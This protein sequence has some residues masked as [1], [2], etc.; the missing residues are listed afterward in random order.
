MKK[1]R[2]SARQI[3]DFLVDE[4]LLHIR[5]ENKSDR[6]MKTDFESAYRNVRRYVAS[7][8]YKRGKGSRIVPKEHIIL[9]RNKYLRLLFKNRQQPAEFCLREVYLDE[10][11]IHQHYHCLDDS[12]WDPNDDQDVFVGKLPRKGNRYCF[13]AAIQGPNP[14]ADDNSEADEDKG[15]LVP[16]SLWVFLLQKK[17]DHQGD[18]HKVFNGANFSQ[19]FRDQLLPKLTVPSLIIMDNAAYYKVYHPRIPKVGKMK[20][21]DVVAYLESEGIE[22]D[23]TMSAVEIREEAK[24]YI[25]ETQKI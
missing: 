8:G 21:A 13:A 7:L 23:P 22:V 17:K 11:Y 14:R 19:W 4:K 12:C 9:A 20:K 16:G 25:K 1:T 24:T 15:G 2:V 3:L 5:K 10:S 6:Y 18:Y